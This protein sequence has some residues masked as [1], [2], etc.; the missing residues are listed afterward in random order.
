ME[1][2]NSST[3]VV[4]NKILESLFPEDNELGE[5]MMQAAKC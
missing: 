3:S 1:S 2:K 4:P 5:E